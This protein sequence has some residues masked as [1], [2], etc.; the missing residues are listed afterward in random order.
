MTCPRVIPG[1]RLHRAGGIPAAVSPRVQNQRF[2]RHKTLR[3][4]YHPAQC[5]VEHHHMI[6]GIN[7]AS[8]QGLAI[9]HPDIRLDGSAAALHPDEGN[10]ARI[11][12]P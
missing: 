5:R 6:R 11:S 7:A 3:D 2:P 4:V 10:P 12:P 9:I 8:D 1:H